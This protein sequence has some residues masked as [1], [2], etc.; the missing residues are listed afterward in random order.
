MLY[1]VITGFL[2]AGVKAGLKR[3][4]NDDMALIYSPKP[5]NFAAAFTSCTFAAAPVQ[6]DRARCATEQTSYNFV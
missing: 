6:L 3:S 1:E 4:G 5:A 2:A